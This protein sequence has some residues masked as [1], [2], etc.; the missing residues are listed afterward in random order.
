MR[1]TTLAV[2]VLIGCRASR[3][4]SGAAPDAAHQKLFAVPFDLVDI[5]DEFW[6]P[7]LDTNREKTLPYLFEMFEKD[8]TI[9]NFDK[10]AGKIQGPHQCN[11]W[12]DGLFYCCLQA[13]S[14]MLAKRPDPALEKK[15]DDFIAR[16]A[17][18]Q[19]ADGYLHTFQQLKE[20]GKRW[21][22]VRGT[23][24]LYDAGQ[25]IE[26]GVAHHQA[27][28]K[29]TLLDV[30]VKFADLI[31]ANFGP[32][33]RSIVSDHAEPELALVKLYRLTG[34]ERYLK[35]ARFLVD[36]HGIARGRQLLG[37]YAQDDK[38]FI[39]QDRPEGHAVR[40]T[41]FYT[42]AA[43][44]AAHT[45]DPGYVRALERIWRH[46]VERRAYITG[47]LGSA[48]QWEGFGEDY[49]LPNENG[50]LETCASIGSAYWNHRM[51]LLMGDARYVD[52]FER[53][54]YNAVLVGVSMDG[55]KFF[56]QNP[57]ATR[58][59]HHRWTW[60]GCPCC[61]PNILKFL[62]SLGS[63]VY[64]R[65]RDAIYVNLYVGSQAAVPLGDQKIRVIQKTRY[66]W[67]G[68]V[69]I[70]VEP[71]REAPF[72]VCL[73]MPGW[74]EKAEVRVNGQAP[75]S[76]DLRSGYLRLAQEWKRG[77]R[78]DLDL[79]MPVR[80]VYA[81]P[82][83]AADR[84]RV[85]LQRGPIIYCLEGADNG[86]HV[87]NLSLPQD[88]RLT[89]EGSPGLLGGVTVVKGT[90]LARGAGAPARKLYVQAPA[91]APWR[92]TELTAVPYFAWD[93]REPGEMVVW[94]PE[95][96]MVAE[97][98]LAVAAS[99]CWQHDTI[100]GLLTEEAPA[101]SN[102]QDLPRYSAW[103]HHGT[104]EWVERRF[105]S[106]RK[107]SAVEVYWYDDSP[108]NVAKVGG[109]VTG[110]CRAPKAWRLFYREGDAWKPVEASGEPGV[111]LNKFNRLGLRPVETKALRIEIDLRPEVT[112]GI[113]AWRIE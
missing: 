87:L 64:A 110:G 55:V 20:P 108:E 13:A 49:D 78:I 82:N 92:K 68:K 104:T 105:E 11:P 9:A 107:V 63:Y 45:G 96:P 36:E 4:L 62:S 46:T 26:A 3:L 48:A 86:G 12:N 80:R 74:C 95:N 73:R 76:A 33:K 6:K 113:L 7:K 24:E 47:G 38:P 61:P 58:G 99:H 85:A 16:I 23:H 19:Q 28:G 34:E 57:L 29:R 31:D 52:V 60:H 65:D 30:A 69:T 79:E 25:L 40:A 106:A 37:A 41:L 27:T 42:G 10:A 90:G 17:A 70:Q 101:H 18:A 22:F 53:T 51:N 84:G 66:P 35:L 75:R 103:P 1:L 21:E 71:E 109:K 77:D 50:Y 98:I 97:P 2:I 39:E 67:E 5:D 93:N 43:D 83:V 100:L 102:D 88:S 54:A 89:A 14:E 56:Y 111:A 44:V 81:N 72:A 59:N 15:L 32:E 8:G 94:L 91:E 112:A